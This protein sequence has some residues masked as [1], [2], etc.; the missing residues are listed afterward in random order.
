MEH[1]RQ[2]YLL[3]A[4][5]KTEKI[6]AT[7]EGTGRNNINLSSIADIL[8]ENVGRF[9]ERYR[10]DFIISWDVVRQ[11]ID[12]PV[13]EDTLDIVAFAIRKDG[14]DSNGFLTCRLDEHSRQPGYSSAYYRRIYTLS[15]LRKNDLSVKCELKDVTD[16][17]D[18]HFRK[19][20]PKLV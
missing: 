15:I 19:L 3:N 18:Y 5:E 13:S 12:E 9:C 6:K 17:A 4:H 2:Q 16:E 7:A 14:V 11:I 8:I 1:Y 10:S 20:N